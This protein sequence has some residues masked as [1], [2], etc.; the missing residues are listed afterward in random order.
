MN[1]VNLPRKKRW[2]WLKQS[3]SV[4]HLPSPQGTVGVVSGSEP[5]P[6]TPS[7]T[8]S[9]RGHYKLFPKL[10]GNIATKSRY[11]QSATQQS[12][13]PLAAASSSGRDLSK[14]KVGAMLA[15]GMLCVITIPQDPSSHTALDF[16]ANP[17]QVVY[18]SAA[19]ASLSNVFATFLW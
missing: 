3:R 18:S 16:K 1:E 4:P 12:L 17:Y 11:T 5:S 19:Q 13:T 14:T 9:P 10:W 6:L 15:L 7:R 2:E 8:G